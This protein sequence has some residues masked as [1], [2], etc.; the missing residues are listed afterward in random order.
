RPINAWSVPLEYAGIS[1]LSPGAATVVTVS[2]LRPRVSL[3]DTATGRE[4]WRVVG[5][6]TDPWYTYATLA[7]DGSWL[8]TRDQ[9]GGLR[10]WEAVTGRRI[11]LQPAGERGRFEVDPAW[12]VSPDGRLIAAEQSDLQAVQLWESATGRPLAVLDGARAPLAFTPD[13]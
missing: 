11:D 13:G 6:D 1:F 7:P 3:W 5:T 4:L 10:L 8:L 2:N 12:A 9:L